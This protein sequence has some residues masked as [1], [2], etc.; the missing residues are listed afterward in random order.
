MTDY[1]CYPLWLIRPNNELDNISPESLPIS[2]DLAESL[3]HWAE[4][5]DAILNEDDP[6][7]SDFAT[8]DDERHFNEHGRQ[9]AERLAREVGSGYKVIYHDI[10]ESKDFPIDISQ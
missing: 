3:N 1:D 10:V 8:P 5:Y 6:A 9:L 7:S 4:E 2:P